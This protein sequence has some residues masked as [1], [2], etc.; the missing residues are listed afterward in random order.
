VLIEYRG[1][2][3]NSQ[4]IDGV[5]YRVKLSIFP[6]MQYL[7]K[8]GKKRANCGTNNQFYPKIRIG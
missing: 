1:V 6:Q 7:K 3:K 2:P 5:P 4:R 8:E